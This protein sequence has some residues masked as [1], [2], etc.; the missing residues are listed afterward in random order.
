MVT[1]TS[2]WSHQL[3]LVTQLQ[4]AY[5]RQ[6]LLGGRGPGGNSQGS[7]PKRKVGGGPRGSFGSVGLLPSLV[8]STLAWE[9][10]QVKHMGLPGTAW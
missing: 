9:V 2:A 3:V 5:E 6:P 7:I 10:G 4:G 1:L 8:L